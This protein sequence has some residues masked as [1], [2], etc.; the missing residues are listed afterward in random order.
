MSSTLEV[1]DF[2][3]PDDNTKNIYISN[4][5]STVVETQ[6]T[7]YLYKS[8]SQFGLLYEV[9][10]L[11]A[12]CDSDG[13]IANGND[14]N[15]AKTGCLYAFVKFYSS[16]C[17]ANALNHCSSCLCLAGQQLRV[18][19]ASRKKS[20]KSVHLYISKCYE[21]ANFYLGFNGYCTSVLMMKCEIKGSADAKSVY[22]VCKV[23][24][25]LPCHGL[26]TTATGRS[27]QPCNTPDSTCTARCR[28][29]KLAYQTA[30]ELSFT[31]LLLVIVNDNKVFVEINSAADEHNILDDD[32]TTSVISVNSLLTDPDCEDSIDRIMPEAAAASR[33]VS[34][35]P[36]TEQDL[37]NQQLLTELESDD[38]NSTIA[39]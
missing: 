33:A 30:V 19:Y 22:S 37:L 16:R 34:E 9:Q 4:I 23:E 13:I 32:S 18:K 38:W 8:F 25:C 3:R 20:V 26:R 39:V 21:L 10:I 12:S 27:V 2:Y 7:E 28:A 5:P 35:K 17:A 31:H 36:H 24:L 29:M 1:I 14:S 6:L 15:D 11:A